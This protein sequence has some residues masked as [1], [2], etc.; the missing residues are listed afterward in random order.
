M[1]GERAAGSRRPSPRRRTLL[2]ALAGALV[3]TAAAAWH[4]QSQLI[5]LGARWYLSRIAAREEAR[6]DLTQRRDAVAR[7]QRLLLLTPIDDAYVPELFDLLTAVSTRVS[8]GQI[9]LPWAA[10]VYTSYQ[11]DLILQRPGGVPRRSGNDVES[12]VRDYVEFYRLEKRPDVQ[13]V[14]LRDLTGAPQGKSFTVEEIEQ[15]A[16]EGRDLTQEE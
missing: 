10:Y 5:G 15:A 9:D 12:A 16:R 1:T 11:R 8:S 7:M 13:G 14:R 6:G 4:W 2:L 3:L